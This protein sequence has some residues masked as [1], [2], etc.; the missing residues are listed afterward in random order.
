MAVKTDRGFILRAFDLRETSK[1]IHVFTKDTGKIHGLL[2]GFRKGKKNFVTSLNTFSLNELVFYE[3]RNDLFLV[4]YADIINDF[5]YLRSNIET[6]TAANYIAELVNKVTPLHFVSRG[7][8]DL[9]NSAFSYL[10]THPSLKIIYIFQIKILEL[11]GF[12][13]HL[14]S[15]VKCE[16]EIFQNAYFSIKLGGFLCPSCRGYDNF[17]KEI[18][19]DFLAGLKYI[20]NNS[21]SQS[22]RLNLSADSEH[23]IFNILEDFLGYHLDTRIKSS[24]GLEKIWG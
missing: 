13:P 8:F 15:C 12:R 4:S 10:S 19:P 20:Q 16:K 9:I 24:F 3:S 1:I 23:D 21:F 22:L 14:T 7:I 5:P 11:T 2:K 6:N 17:S 18:R